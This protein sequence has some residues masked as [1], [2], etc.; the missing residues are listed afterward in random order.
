MNALVRTHLLI[1]TAAG[2]RSMFYCK[3]SMILQT[4][5][6]VISRPI[7]CTCLIGTFTFDN[8]LNSHVHFLYCTG[9]ISKS[10]LR[11]LHLYCIKLIY[12][13]L[14][15]LKLKMYWRISTGLYYFKQTLIITLLYLLDCDGGVAYLEKE[16]ILCIF[17][18][19]IT[20]SSCTHFDAII[21]S[22]PQPSPTRSVSSSCDFPFNVAGVENTWKWQICW[23]WNEMKYWC[24]RPLFC[25]IK[26]ELGRG[27]LGL[28]RW[29]FYETYP[30]S[31][32][33]TCWKYEAPLS[34]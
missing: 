26:A 28:M 22:P 13:T 9:H 1:C 25:T 16:I 27:Q 10:C 20:R 24:F 4:C 6:D 11:S 14:K 19:L 21:R 30:R 32:Q 34:F 17:A 33:Q 12:S 23:K 5:G 3:D 8:V 7:I 15:K 29:N 18:N 31:T 2:Q